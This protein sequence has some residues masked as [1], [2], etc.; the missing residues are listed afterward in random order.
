MAIPDP[1]V[2]AESSAANTSKSVLSLTTLLSS[3]LAAVV[4]SWRISNQLPTH[5]TQKSESISQGTYPLTRTV[6]PN[7][8]W[9]HISLSARLCLYKE[10]GLCTRRYTGLGEGRCKFLLKS[11]HS[12][13]TLCEAIFVRVPVI[14][15][16]DVKALCKQGSSIANTRCYIYY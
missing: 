4:S 16:R 6:I 12:Y 13:V 14:T 1:T 3:F 10:V 2:L 5:E 11:C 7:F 8:P 15:H 9:E